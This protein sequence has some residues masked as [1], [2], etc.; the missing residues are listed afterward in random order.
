VRRLRKKGELVSVGIEVWKSGESTKHSSSLQLKAIP[1]NSQAYMVKTFSE[2]R[3]REAA[4]LS[5]FLMMILACSRLGTVLNI[6]IH[7]GSKDALWQREA[8]CQSASCLPG[9]D[10]VL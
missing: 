3:E 4:C 10:Q 8:P 9:Q 1:K 2:E 6:G 7:I 5:T